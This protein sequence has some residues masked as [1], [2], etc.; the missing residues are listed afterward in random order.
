M[1]FWLWPAVA[2]AVAAAIILALLSSV[3]VRVRYSHSGQF[4]QLIV[5][6]KALYGLVRFRAIVPSIIV[7]SCGIVYDQLN[8]SSMGKP[9]DDR[10]SLNRGSVRRYGRA[11][12][13]L[14]LSTR[15]FRLWLLATMKKVEC[16]RWRMDITVGTGDA[17][18]TSA[19]AG[20]FWTVLGCAVAATSRFMRMRTHPHGEVKPNFAH[21]ELS[22]VC[23]ADFRIRLSTLA[24]AGIR[25]MTRTVSPIKAYK[26]VRSLTAKPKTA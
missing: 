21:A 1:A 16:T 5:I 17:A 8:S 25:L 9:K 3:R 14:E 22:V 18:L 12:R 19:A 20:L 7:R 4:D 13:R 26:A 24:S 15:R 10:R 11:I 2:A 23:E 6:V